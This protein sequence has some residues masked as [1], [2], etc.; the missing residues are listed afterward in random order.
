MT[1]ATNNPRTGRAWSLTGEGRKLL[2][3]CAGVVR[4]GELVP[5]QPGFG[6]PVQC[7]RWN[8]DTKRCD[9]EPRTDYQGF[10]VSA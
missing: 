3:G 9:A 7:P 2:D 4:R 10:P 6:M 8:S 1:T 5:G